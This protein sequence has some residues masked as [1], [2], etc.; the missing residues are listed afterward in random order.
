MNLEE[1]NILLLDK[2]KLNNKIKGYIKTKNIIKSPVISEEIKGHVEKAEHNLVFVKD[3]IKLGHQDWCITGSYYA[4]YHA[5]LALIN[6]KGYNSKSHDAT[7][8][9]LILEFLGNNLTEEEIKLLNYVFLEQND[10]LFYSQAKDKREDA[11]YS[12]KYS[13]EIKETEEIRRQ[14]IGFVNKSKD[15][16][17]A[18]GVG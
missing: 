11:S 14:A 13:F 4:I 18:L 12:T 5:S 16:L 15:I 8:C 17:M 3:N 10:I 7:L 1:L 2:N 9:L 6:A